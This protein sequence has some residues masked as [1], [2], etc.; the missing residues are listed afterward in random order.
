[1]VTSFVYFAP[2]SRGSYFVTKVTSWKVLLFRIC[3]TVFFMAFF[4]KVLKLVADGVINITHRIIVGG[5]SKADFCD[6]F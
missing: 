5:V 6:I 4:K 1:L 3:V 2:F